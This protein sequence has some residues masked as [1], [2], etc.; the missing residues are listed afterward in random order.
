MMKIKGSR[1]L[2]LYLS[3]EI[4]AESRRAAASVSHMALPPPPIPPSPS[5]SIPHAPPLTP[6]PAEITVHDAPGV[7]DVISFVY[8]LSFLVSS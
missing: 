3:D 7:P 1:Q 4:P 5:P 8:A 6:P 2:H